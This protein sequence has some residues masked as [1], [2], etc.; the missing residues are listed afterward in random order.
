MVFREIGRGMELDW[1][2]RYTMVL[3]LSLSVN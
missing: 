3:A 1:R 2:R